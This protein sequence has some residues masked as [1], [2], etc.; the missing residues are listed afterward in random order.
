MKKLWDFEV[1]KKDFWISYLMNSSVLFNMTLEQVTVTSQLGY[2]NSLP[3][4][5]SVS[6]LE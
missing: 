4:G 1:N 6:P 5:L 2:S 3:A